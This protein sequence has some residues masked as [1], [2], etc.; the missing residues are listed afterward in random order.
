[1]AAVFSSVERNWAEALQN[2]VQVARWLLILWSF[3]REDVD[4]KYGGLT[5]EV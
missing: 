2:D 4:D 1:M 5:L 3:L